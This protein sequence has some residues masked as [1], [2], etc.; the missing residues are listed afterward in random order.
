MGCGTAPCVVAGVRRMGNGDRLFNFSGSGGGP[1]WVVGVGVVCGWILYLALG[2]LASRQRNGSG[3]PGG[4]DL[5][6][7]CFGCLGEEERRT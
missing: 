6:Q 7:V 2:V 5:Q 3:G 1:G 4:E